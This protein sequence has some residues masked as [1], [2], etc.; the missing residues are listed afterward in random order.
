MSSLKESN[1]ALQKNKKRF[2]LELSV[3]N[4]E[5]YSHR[6]CLRITSIPCEEKGTREEV[7]KKLQKIINEEAEVDIP[8]ETIDRAHCVGPKKKKSS[9]H[10]Y[11]FHV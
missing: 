8:E 2:G 5:Q 11:F 1:I 6:T 9:Y 7:L 4:D 10:S 3:E